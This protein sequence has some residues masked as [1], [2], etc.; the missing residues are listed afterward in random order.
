MTKEE[1]AAALDHYLGE[2][3]R[4]DSAVRLGGDLGIKLGAD[5]RNAYHN[6][7]MYGDG[8][9]WRENP[10]DCSYPARPGV[11]D[12]GLYQ[13]SLSFM[14]AVESIVKRFG[15]ESYAFHDD[16]F[17]RTRTERQEQY[18]TIIYNQ[19]IYETVLREDPDLAFIIDSFSGDMF[20][21]LDLIVRLF[22]EELSAVVQ[23]AIADNRAIFIVYM[24]LTFGGVYLVLFRMAVRDALR[25]GERAR[26]FVARIPTHALSQVE[27][28]TIM[29]MFRPEAGVEAAED[30]EH[31]HPQGE[32]TERESLASRPSHATHAVPA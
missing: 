12:N 4:A 21:G 23:G 32:H 19:T 28:E 17:F 18:D 1:M 16:N 20:Q 13:L 3:R 10:N 24:I 2:L 15:P 11:A 27:A 14:D 5:Y 31:D 9:E 25:E 29:I 6:Q 8:C 22:D 7:I 30:I 26:T